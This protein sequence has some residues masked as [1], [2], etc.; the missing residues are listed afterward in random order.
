M[1]KQGIYMLIDKVQSVIERIP[2][3][4]FAALIVVSF[5]NILMNND[6]IEVVLANLIGAIC[7]A[8]VTL[9]NWKLKS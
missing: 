2:W 4:I 6:K 7:M 8:Y 3:Y 1:A 5:L 9:H